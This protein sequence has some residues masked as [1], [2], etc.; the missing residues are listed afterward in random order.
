MKLNIKIQII[1]IVFL[2]SFVQIVAKAQEKRLS[3]A[4]GI[5]FNL[6]HFPNVNYPLENKKPRNTIPSMGLL[7]NNNINNRFKLISNFSGSFKNFDKIHVLDQNKLNI[8]LL[9]GLSRNI[10][11]DNNF[12]NPYIT[13]GFGI[14]YFNNYIST[15]LPIGA[16]IE[17]QISSD[18]NGQANILHWFSLSNREVAKTSIGLSLLGFLP[19]KNTKKDVEVK[20]NLFLAA[21]DSDGDGINDM[22]D[23]CPIIPGILKYKG[24]PAAESS[25]GNITLLFYNNIKASYA[26]N[27]NTN[28]IKLQALHPSSSIKSKLKNLAILNSNEELKFHAKNIHF[29]SGSDELKSESFQPLIKI[30]EILKNNPS[31]LIFIEGHTDNTGSDSLNSSL[32]LRRAL[33]VKNFL[34]EKGI[35]TERITATGYGDSFPLDSNDHSMGRQLNRR[36]EIKISN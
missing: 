7:Y 6:L 2:L 22:E 31:A 28:H 13:V 14:N 24:C 32:S 23:A 5:T 21:K 30:S 33:A 29:E 35:N 34:S 18:I 36:V 1:Y 8:D 27:I 20:T 17:F 11:Y 15:N 3:S 19:N 9:T 16:G 12:I 4:I 26:L 10:F 25:F